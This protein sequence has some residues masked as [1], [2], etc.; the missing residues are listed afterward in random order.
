MRRKLVVKLV[1][2]STCTCER[3]FSD[4]WR[5]G[6]LNQKINLNVG[7]MVGIYEIN[8]LF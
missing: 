4:A 2:L 7:V 1:V 5:L 6:A 3:F 8:Y